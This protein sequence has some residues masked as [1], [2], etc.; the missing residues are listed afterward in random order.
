[1]IRH[2][3]FCNEDIEVVSYQQFGYHVSHCS[4]NPNSQH[5]SRKISK[6]KTTSKD[7]VLMCAKCGNEYT[8]TLT[9]YI[10][11]S[12]KYTKHCSR[13]CA[14]GKIHSDE[15]RSK[16]KRASDVHRQESYID[17]ICIECNNTFLD[18]PSNRRPLCHACRVIYCGTLSPAQKKAK[19]VKLS[20][21]KLLFYQL[22]P[23][24]H[25][26]RL[27]AGKKQSY[28]ETMFYEYLIY[29]GL[30]PNI[31]FIQ[32]HR[33]G[34]YYVDF[35]FP[36]ISTGI[37]I[38][39][40]YWHDLTSDREITRADFIKAKINLIR[41]WAADITAKNV[42]NDINDIVSLINIV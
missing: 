38:D 4:C 15:T 17:H 37:E 20:A 9:D 1:M 26:N 29:L 10:Y 16:I 40:E 25:P 5:L 2:C 23:D 41:F 7:R 19:S 32:Q 24:K 42:E 33:V 22:Y 21:T 18:K 30:I 14:N 31:H 3:K 6:T 27:R 12:G 28:P 39:G 36:S 13:S 35:Y 34:R 11:D 8:L